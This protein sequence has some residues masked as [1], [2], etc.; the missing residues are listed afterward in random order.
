MFI[1]TDHEVHGTRNR[2]FS[3]SL[4]GL[5]YAW[6]ILKIRKVLCQEQVN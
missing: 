3:F 5:R 4:E 1:A 2:D 6:K